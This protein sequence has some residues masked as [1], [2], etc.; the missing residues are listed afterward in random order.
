MKIYN[1]ESKLNIH[2]FKMN[3]EYFVFDYHQFVTFKTTQSFYEFLTYGVYETYDENK[4][5][6]ERMLLKKLI[7][8]NLLCSKNKFNDSMKNGVSTAYLSFAPIYQCNFN[9]SYCFGEAGHAYL[10]KPESF[11]SDLVLKTLDFFF[12]KAF[13][14]AQ[15][16]RIDFVSGGEPLLNFDAIK[17]AIQ[18]SEKIQKEQ[19]K[20]V[21]IWLCTNGSLLTDEICKYL[22]DN[23]ISIGISIDGPPANH[24]ANRVDS[25]GKPT[26]DRVYERIK[27]IKTNPELSEK[28]KN[29]W[30]LS[31]INPQNSNITNIIKHHNSLGLNNAQ[32]K[33]IRS[34][35]MPVSFYEELKKN[36]Y[37]FSC[38]LL[39]NFSNGNYIY[40]NM[41][42]N[43]NDYFGKIIKRILLK[44]AYIYRCR[45]GRNKITI[46]PN[47]DIF[48]CDSFVGME[49]HKL[50][51]IYSSYELQKSIFYNADVSSRKK[52]NSCSVKYLC[53][54][55]CY[56][57]SYINTGSI[58]EPDEKFCDIMKYLCNLSIWL[59][60][61][62]EIIN[63]SELD[64]LI[65]FLEINEHFS[66]I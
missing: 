48:P 63:R 38:F 50:G 8:K 58:L 33:I 55:D 62:M 56:Y 66:N 9:C 46:C 10:E 6:K 23:R 43:D 26:Y 39:N 29:I 21:Y 3:D 22:D 4:Y 20:S 41:I 7:E 54:G 37:E 45:A 59:C 15:H 57:N 16:Y 2:T 31:V 53:G 32:L 36:Y 14:Q 47:G 25:L 12:N 35:K 44:N 52:C 13:P 18:Y 28:F 61:E 24:N 49:E 64:N 65:K 11:N 19:K 30:A 40:L 27:K 42:L 34:S 60:C 1:E 17:C 51:N 5:V